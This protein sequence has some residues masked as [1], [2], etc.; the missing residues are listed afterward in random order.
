[1]EEVMLQCDCCPHGQAGKLFET[2]IKVETVTE[3]D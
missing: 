1:M 3:Q 2:V